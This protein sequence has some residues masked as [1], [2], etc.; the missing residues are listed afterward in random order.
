MSIRTIK[1]IA[2]ICNVSTSTVSRAINDES[3]INKET[4]ARILKVVEEYNFIPNSSARDLK[5]L[6]SNT[7][8]LLIQG[9][10]N[11][12]FQGMFAV[13]ER[14]LKKLKFSFSIH[15]VGEEQD[16]IDVAAELIK[17]KHLKGLIFLGGSMN[18][19]A[20]KREQLNIP[21]VRCSGTL[22]PD[23][24]GYDGTSN[25]IDDEEESYRI[26]NYLCNKGHRKIAVIIS[27]GKDKSIAALRMQ[28]YRRALEENQIPYDPKLIY[29][30]DNAVEDFSMQNGYIT[31]KKLLESGIKFTA[32]YASSDTLAFGAYKAI[33]EYGKKIPDDYSV[34]GFDGIEMGKYYCPSLTTLTQPV[35][36]MAKTAIDQ[37]MK[38]IHEEEI[39]KQIVFQGILTER[40]S[41]K[42]IYQS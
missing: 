35:E 37:L 4:K 21:S 7:I 12:F 24:Q 26:V 16:E 20:K 3:G 22:L 39:K 14:E 41:V 19:N 23:V 30:T 5:K 10:S 33:Y 42:N 18:G 38:A 1:D 9:I 2:K 15:S 40:E 32:L 25:A 27:H 36:E 31:T 34:V 11:P 28:G 8:A 6:E 17:E 29:T 13:F